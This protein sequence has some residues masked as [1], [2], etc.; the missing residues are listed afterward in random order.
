MLIAIMVKKVIMQILINIHTYVN[1][2]FC[3]FSK[4]SGKRLLPP[5]GLNIQRRKIYDWHCAELQYIICSVYDLCVAG[6]FGFSGNDPFQHISHAGFIGLA[7]VGDICCYLL[8]RA[9]L[10]G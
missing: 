3:F 6:V 9:A 4:K 10:L 2:V 5:A 1:T 7:Y 8:N